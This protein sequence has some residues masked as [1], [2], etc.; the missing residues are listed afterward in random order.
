MPFIRVDLVKQFEPRQDNRVYGMDRLL[1]MNQY[2][3]ALAHTF[4]M[5]ADSNVNNPIAVRVVGSDLPDPG[6]GIVYLSDPQTTTPNKYSKLTFSLNI[7]SAPFPFY[8]VIFDTTPAA[9]GAGLCWAYADLWWGE[10]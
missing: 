6:G 8:G 5:I 9:P 4:Y 7:A 1:D 3:K 10:G 2:P